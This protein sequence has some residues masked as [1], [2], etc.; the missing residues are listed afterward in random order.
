MG[1]L[2]KVQEKE[3]TQILVNQVGEQLVHDLLEPEAQKQEMN[4]KAHGY[5]RTA[6]HSQNLSNGLWEYFV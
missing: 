2:H 5:M 4:D 1:P 6:T 3:R